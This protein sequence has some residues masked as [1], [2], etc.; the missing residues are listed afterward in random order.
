MK[1]Y[2]DLS[3]MALLGI[4]FR[5]QPLKRSLIKVSPYLARG[6]FLSLEGMRFQVR[7]IG[8]SLVVYLVILNL[9]NWYSDSLSDQCYMFQR[10]GILLQFFSLHPFAIVLKALKRAPPPCVNNM[11]RISYVICISLLLFTT[12]Y[13]VLLLVVALHSH[14]ESLQCLLLPL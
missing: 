5:G 7:C 4:F 11:Q 9:S 10:H 13:L 3:T 8:R 14:K 1:D 12:T 2:W 6:E